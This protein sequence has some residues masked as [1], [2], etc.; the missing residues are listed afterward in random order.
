M[1]QKTCQY[2]GG[3]LI[4]LLDSNYH[5]KTFLYLYHENR[6]CIVAKFPT[7]QDFKT[8]FK[9][10]LTCTFLSLRAHSQNTVCVD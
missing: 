9:Q 4:D 5:E 2:V 10:N 3:N 8:P 6:L 7:S 1:H